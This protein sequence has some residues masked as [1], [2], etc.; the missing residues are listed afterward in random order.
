MFLFLIKNFA[1]YFEI[2][3]CFPTVPI[4]R[5]NLASF[6]LLDKPLEEEKKRKVRK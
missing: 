6:E 1:I 4:H 5:K 3:T 2:H